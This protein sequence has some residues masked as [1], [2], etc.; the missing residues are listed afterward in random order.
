MDVYTL[1]ELQYLTNLTYSK[2]KQ[3]AL[4]ILYST[5]VTTR[6]PLVVY[7]HGGGWRTGEK[8]FRPPSVCFL[9]AAQGFAVS[10][11]NYRLSWTA[12]FPAQVEDC[13]EAIHWLCNRAEEFGIEPTSI[14]VMGYSAGGHLSALLGTSQG[15]LGAPT[16]FS[17]MKGWHEHPN[18]DE[19][20]FIGGPIQNHPDR[21]RMANPV[22]YVTGKEPP[23]LLIHGERD[24]IIPISQSVLLYQALKKAETDVTMQIVKNADH[25]FAGALTPSVEEIN[26]I[27]LKFFQ[28][29]LAP[30]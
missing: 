2:E 25:S 11:I 14:G 23:F 3:L 13:T 6:K 29:R 1:P 21:V 24:G 5:H 18:S 26:Q 7:I 27:I 4:D 12:K 17:K 19:S 30:M 22:T 28:E 16:D 15:T 20:M 9:L 8:T 10:M